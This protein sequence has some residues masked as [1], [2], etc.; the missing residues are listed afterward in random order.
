MTGIVDPTRDLQWGNSTSRSLHMIT[1]RWKLE[2]LWLLK[3]RVH[4]FAELKRAIPGIT[5]NMLTT[6]LRELE[7]D[8]L[9]KRTVYAEVPVRVEYEIMPLIKELRPMFRVIW[10]WCGFTGDPED[11]KDEETVIVSREKFR[12]GLRMI[13]GRW[14]LDILWLLNQRVHRF[15]ELRRALPGLT[16]HILT[17]QLRELE[18]NGLVKRTA[19]PEVPLRV[20]YEITAFGAQL[21]PLFATILQWAK[22]NTSHNDTNQPKRK[23]AK[24][25]HPK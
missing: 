12:R 19:Y 8:G 11:V 2:I 21:K 20:E 22:D 1:G 23:A 6:Q 13:S 5:Q 24:D 4:R 18:A 3:Y 7:A 25:K 15:G 14:K 17:V 16:Q 9:I 10:K